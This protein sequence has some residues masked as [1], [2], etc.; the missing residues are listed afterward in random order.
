ML[1]LDEAGARTLDA[2][3]D[4]H[5]RVG[6]SLFASMAKGSDAD[7]L[8]PA[9]CAKFGLTARQYNAVSIGL[10]GKVKS[11]RAIVG[12]LAGVAEAFQE[13]NVSGETSSHEAPARNSAVSKLRT[14]MKPLPH[15][16]AVTKLWEYIRKHNLQDATDRGQHRASIRFWTWFKK[17][18]WIGRAQ[19]PH[20]FS[21]Q[22]LSSHSNQPCELKGRS[23]FSLG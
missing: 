7:E 6:R 11:L 17:Q 5:G 16:E 8:K 21:P 23:L 1:R 13:E 10:K 12:S 19:D 18:P 22:P 15:R 9:F 4:L 2:F 14:F 3:A 20:D